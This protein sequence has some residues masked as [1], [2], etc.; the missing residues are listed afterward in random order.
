[1]ENTH[2]LTK[3][4]AHLY[5]DGKLIA[6]KSFNNLSERKTVMAQLTKFGEKR[7]YK[8]YIELKSA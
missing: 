6:S 1:M 7:Y 2:L 3:G 5:H 8:F 4:F